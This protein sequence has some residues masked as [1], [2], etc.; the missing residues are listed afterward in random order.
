MTD[1]KQPSI[2]N[3]PEEIW[4]VYGDI[5]YDSDHSECN[6]VTWCSE[7]QYPA[8]VRYVRADTV[9]R[10][11]W[12]KPSE[13]LPEPGDIISVKWKESNHFDY[14]SWVYDPVEAGCEWGFVEVWMKL[15]KPCTATEVKKW[16]L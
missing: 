14:D 6:E 4:L 7:S 13:R 9:E 5:E 1:E 16:I 12:T 15:P 3:A 10:S 11:G 2:L 8:D